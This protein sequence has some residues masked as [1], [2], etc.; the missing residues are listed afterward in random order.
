MIVA[1]CPGA[2]NS[3]AHIP[4]TPVIEDILQG[5]QS[6]GPYLSPNIS[7]IE[8]WDGN[9]EIVEDTE[10]SPRSMIAAMPLY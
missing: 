3:P 10:A 9:Q 2:T 7:E 4:T 1:R 6:A 5:S 8:W